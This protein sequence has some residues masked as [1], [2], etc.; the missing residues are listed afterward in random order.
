MLGN[1]VPQLHA[2][3][4]ARFEGD[5]AWPNPVWGGAAAAYAPAQLAEVAAGL[6]R[7][8]FG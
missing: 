1:Q 5:A 7:A 4:I 2:H 8:L 3:V 6:K